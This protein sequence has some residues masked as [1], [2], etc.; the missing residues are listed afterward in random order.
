M[1]EKRFK[2]ALKNSL[3]G[4]DF[5]VERQL[6]VLNAIEGGKTVKKKISVAFVCAIIL[7]V[8]LA[9]A[10]LAAVLGVFGQFSDH[11]FYQMSSERL[12]RLD[13]VAVSVGA[14]VTLAA[15]EAPVGEAAQTVRDELIAHQYGRTFT[16]TLNQAYIDGN[17]AYYSYT[18]ST[19][20][21]D[22]RRGEGRPSGFEAWDIEEPGR[23]YE[24][25]WAND[26]PEIDREITEWLN[27]HES[28]WIALDSWDLA[29]GAKLADGTRTT[30]L[31]SGSERV[32]AYTLHGYQE[33][34]LPEGLEDAESIELVFS[35]LYG[36]SVYY[37]DAAGHA[38]ASIIEPESQGVLNA[39]F[40]VSRTGQVRDV[41]GEAVFDRYGVKVALRISDV[42]VSGTATLSCPPEWIE[43]ITENGWGSESDYLISYVL[44]DGSKTLRNLDGSLNR[45][46]P[47]VLEIS[48]RYDLPEALESLTLRPVYT[49]SGE[50]A[51]E[52]VA[53]K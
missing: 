48:L 20:V 27:A 15:P 23:K 7:S 1:N 51:A 43:M 47:G 13:E 16:F 50:R 32:D 26:D 2:T 34:E 14:Q 46:E 29:D 10:A 36:T 35:I 49:R 11:K 5:P 25:V 31:E 30:I 45:P 12:K 39:S 41:G 42:D 6:E 9:G 44:V 40:V 18:L 3:S 4:S 21:S 17:K 37:Q 19:N 8:A 38:W 33:V 24:D 22:T 52:D 28:A 53:T